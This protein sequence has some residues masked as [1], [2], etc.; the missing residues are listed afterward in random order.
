MHR[1]S[2]M[3]DKIDSKLQNEENHSYLD[4]EEHNVLLHLRESAKYVEIIHPDEKVWNNL[5]AK[6]RSKQNVHERATKRKQSFILGLIGIAASFSFLTFSYFSYQQN[7]A[8]QEFSAL[9]KINQQ[10]ESQ[11]AQHK[12]FNVHSKDILNQLLKTEIELSATTDLNGA[13]HQLRERKNLMKILLELE[14][15]AELDVISI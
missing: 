6:L 5:E 7:Q 9:L 12:Y 11:L 2:N 10:L 3:T 13:N 8:I 15:T 4:E 14:L 1:N